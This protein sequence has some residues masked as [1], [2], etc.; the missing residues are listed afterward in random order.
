MVVDVIARFATQDEIPYSGIAIDRGDESYRNTPPSPRNR[1]KD[2]KASSKA[3]ISEKK[4]RRK[5]EEGK[6][7]DDTLYTE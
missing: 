1:A 7:T 5:I 4:T 2:R 3:G 6:E